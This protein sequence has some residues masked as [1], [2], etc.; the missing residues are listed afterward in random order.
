MADRVNEWT[1]RFLGIPLLRIERRQEI[2]G[3]IERL[4]DEE[5]SR[6]RNPITSPTEPEPDWRELSKTMKDGAHILKRDE[7]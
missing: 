2:V 5:E 6:R 3:V 1:V 4:V 7:V